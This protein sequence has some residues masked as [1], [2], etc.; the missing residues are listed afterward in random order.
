MLFSCLC[1]KG[2]C[3]LYFFLMGGTFL[4]LDNSYLRKSHRDRARSHSSV[5]PERRSRPRRSPPLSRESAGRTYRRRSVS[6][7]RRRQRS[8]SEERRSCRRSQRKYSPGS[9]SS[10]RSS[11][12]N[13]KTRQE[14]PKSA[15]T[16]APAA[17]SNQPASMPK[18]V[19]SNSL[20]DE[21]AKQV[22]VILQR[23]REV[24]ET[25]H[26]KQE[27]ENNSNRVLMIYV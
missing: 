8:S 7:E 2:D 1:M 25:H 18:R 24:T 26:Q 10:S 13:S 22:Q 14:A 6:R 11:R 20:A 9:T 3:I 27:A 21:I 4:L 23:S 19:F 16:S 17:K 12:S 5:S 15:S